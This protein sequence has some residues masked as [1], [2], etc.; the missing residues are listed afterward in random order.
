MASVQRQRP[1]TVSAKS[2]LR[3]EIK[4][5]TEAAA[6]S[7]YRSLSVIPVVGPALGVAAAG[8]VIA[9]GAIRASNLMGL[10]GAREHGGNVVAG[11]SYLVGERGYE[12]FTPSVSGKISNHHE[13]KGMVNSA[14]QQSYKTAMPNLNVHIENRVPAQFHVE[15]LS[16]TDVKII[17]LEVAQQTV[18]RDA[19]KVIAGDLANPNSRVSSSLNRNTLTQRKRNG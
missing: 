2:F 16:A 14:A 19:P 6:M 11:Q 10:S 5:D 1:W 9:Y 15:R 12:V 3:S 13:S 4:A 8:A 18:R 17:A 7:A